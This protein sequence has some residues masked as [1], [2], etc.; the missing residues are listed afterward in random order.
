VELITRQRYLILTLPLRMHDLFDQAEESEILECGNA[1]DALSADKAKRLQ[2]VQERL[3]GI[4][5]WTAP[6]RAEE[7][8]RSVGLKRTQCSSSMSELSGGWRMRVAL[9][10]VLY[11]R[12]D[13]LLLDGEFREFWWSLMYVCSRTQLGTQC[14]CQSSADPPFDKCPVM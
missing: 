3:Q 10:A 12:P 8:L 4:D 7:I 6:D 9:A 13:V 1:N 5:A 14:P 2:D 11:S